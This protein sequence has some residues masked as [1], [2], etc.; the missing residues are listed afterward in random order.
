MTS[1]LNEE[2]I[3]DDKLV[4]VDNSTFVKDDKKVSR[5]GFDK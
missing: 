4:E 5:Q 3:D 2:L 1:D